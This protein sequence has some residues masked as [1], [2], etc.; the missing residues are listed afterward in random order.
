MALNTG[1]AKS[2]TRVVRTQSNHF[3]AAIYAFVKLER[4][5]IQ[6]QLN[7]FALKGRLYLNA[8]KTSF[9]ELQRLQIAMA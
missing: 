3:F 8:L 2:P 7:H 5:K 9:A 6:H 1:L 4:L